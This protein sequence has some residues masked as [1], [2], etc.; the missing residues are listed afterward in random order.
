MSQQASNPQQTE[1]QSSP[2]PV[3]Q[4]PEA[5]TDLGMLTK[6]VVSSI[7]EVVDQLL[8][9]VMGKLG[10]TVYLTI[11]DAIALS[12]IQ[13]IPGLIYKS[14]LGKNFSGYDVCML[15]NTF[16]TSCVAC[17]VIVTF[18]YLFWILLASRFLG[19]VLINIKDYWKE[20][21]DSFKS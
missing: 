11:Q 6:N 4:S 20:F 9:I 7:F 21:K 18:K 14:I 10:R 8:W 17:Y 5:K 15:G 1:P 13:R 2:P 12:L 16:D 3:P 19:R